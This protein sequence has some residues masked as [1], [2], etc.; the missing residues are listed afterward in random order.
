VRCPANAARWLT[1][2]H[3][4]VRWQEAAT[5]PTGFKGTDVF[6]N[7]LG[8]V[9]PAVY[10]TQHGVRNSLKQMVKLLSQPWS[11][12]DAHGVR[13]PGR[14]HQF[15]NTG[16]RANAARW[17]WQ[18]SSQEVQLLETLQGKY[19]KLPYRGN[20]RPPPLFSK[21]SS[22]TMADAAAVV[23]PMLT[24]LLVQTDLPET[25]KELWTHFSH[26]LGFMTR[27]WFRKAGLPSAHDEML[28]LSSELDLR[29]P[30]SFQTIVNHIQLHHFAEKRGV[31]AQAGGDNHT[32]GAERMNKFLK[33]ISHSRK[34]MDTGVERRIGT[35]WAVAIER[36]KTMPGE[37]ATRPQ[38]S[39]GA[40]NSV[41]SMTL[42]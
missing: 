15:R 33:N 1:S 22:F 25:Y 32:M 34:A 10:C 29:L 42:T 16:A 5:K 13:H 3:C 17:K 30:C 36:L 21:L 24:Y 6:T 9:I 41:R 39:A 37:V 19:C 38:H 28:G 14:N 26:V 35:A 7:T 12:A 40:S 2:H 11:H 31:V 18:I 4:H 8:R 20:A 27:K 23:G